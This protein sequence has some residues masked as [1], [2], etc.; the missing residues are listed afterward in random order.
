[1]PYDN[2]IDLY[3]QDL[4]FLAIVE[5]GRTIGYNVTVGGGMGRTHGNENTFAHLGQPICFVEPGEVVATSEA[6]IK[7]F[8]DHGNRADRKRA[9]I[10]YVVYD[11]G[12]EKVREV[13]AR[14][15]LGKP[16]RLPKHVAITDV[17]L[18]L[19]WHAQGDGKWFLGL[20]I[21]NGRVKDDGN[22]RLRTGV[23]KIVETIGAN[24]R[25]TGQQDLLL[26]DIDT[27]NRAVVDKL[28]AEHGIPRPENLSVV[29]KWSM[30]CPAI[31]TCGLAISE[32]ERALPGI[33]DAL[34]P[35]LKA[36][37]LEN[38]RISIRMTGCPNGCAR[39]YQSEIGI[40]GRSGDKYTLYLG[41][42]T[43]GERLNATFQ[44][45]VPREQ[46]VPLLKK[47]LTQFEQDH[48]AGESFGDYCNRLGNE[49][50]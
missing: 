14:D 44:D 46:I 2:C 20:S 4:G 18:H 47:V 1:M 23:H 39:P 40:V 13:L 31:P 28:L 38:E 45:L 29:R 32:S 21:E 24:V 22:L 30:A 36:L 3:A 26:C 27:P 25:N 41:G 15:Y 35:E 42:S 43:L 9:R 10:K 16:I 7:F 37:G 49:R 12:V 50:P 6:V 48:Q 34:E 33:V 5:N 8:R 11:W 17:D 19:G